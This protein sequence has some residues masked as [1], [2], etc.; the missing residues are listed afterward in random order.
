MDSQVSI[1]SVRNQIANAIDI[2]VHLKRDNK[3]RRRV[4]EVA[5]LAGYDGGEYRIN[6][7]YKADESGAIRATGNA[8]MDR[9]RLI[10]TGY[11]S[12]LKNDRFKNLPA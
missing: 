8:L 2:F 1:N 4:E 7:L 6:Y 9:D 11:G 3:G 5:E 12:V 10:R